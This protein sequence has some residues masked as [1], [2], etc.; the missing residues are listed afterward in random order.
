MAVNLLLCLIYRLKFINIH[1]QK[2]STARIRFGAIPLESH[3]AFPM[4]KELLVLLKDRAQY[5]NKY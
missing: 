4:D 3:H 1:V 2:N 5:K